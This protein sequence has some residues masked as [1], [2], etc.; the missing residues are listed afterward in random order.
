[1]NDEQ[2]NSNAHQHLA[3]CCLTPILPITPSPHHPNSPP[4]LLPTPDSRF[5]TPYSRFPILNS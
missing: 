5:P 1:M 2:L 3:C 4:F